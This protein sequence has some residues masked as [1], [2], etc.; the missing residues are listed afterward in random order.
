[1]NSYLKTPFTSTMSKI[2]GSGLL[3][4]GCCVGA[5]MLGLPVVSGPYGFFPTCCMFIVGYLYMLTSGCMLTRLLIEEKERGAKHVHLLSLSE[6]ILGVGGKVVT[7]VL[8]GFLFYAVLTAYTIGSAKLLQEIINSF[9]PSIH[10]SLRLYAF[11]STAVIA[12]IIIKGT[13]TVDYINRLCLLGL[14]SVYLAILVMASTEVEYAQLE[15]SVWNFSLYTTLPV[16]VFSFGYHNLLPS[17]ASYLD[18]NF[19]S[20]R[21]AIVLGTTLSFI[22]YILWEAVIFGVVPFNT[23]AEWTQFIQSGEMITKVLSESIGVCYFTDMMEL[24]AFFAIITS[25]LTVGISMTDFLRDGIQKEKRDSSRGVYTLLALVPPLAIGV[26][27]P[28]LFLAALSYS[29]GVIAILLF[30]ILPAIYRIARPSL[31]SMSC[32]KAKIQEK[33]LILF[34]I[35]GGLFI[36]ALEIGTRTTV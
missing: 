6:S 11:F 24:F 2:F 27:Y 1:M 35:F 12:L 34:L 18:F 7:W 15:R 3:I 16:I 30:G 9:F 17:I 26:S 28:S 4:T 22:T 14:I 10:F 36:M 13:K 32:R 21:K 31:A 33:A 25:Y 29:G 8:F 19:R 23:S 5:G 20:V